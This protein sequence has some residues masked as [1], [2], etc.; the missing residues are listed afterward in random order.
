MPNLEDVIKGLECCDDMN[1]KTSCF[2]CPYLKTNEDEGMVGCT[3]ELARDALALLKEREPRVMTL[4]EVM[5]TPKGIAIWQEIKD[6]PD[7]K[8]EISPVAEPSEIT[9]DCNDD[10]FNL[11]PK[12]PIIGIRFASEGYMPKE[13]YGATWRCWTSRPTDEQRKVVKWDD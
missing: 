6:D 5:A 10:W 11:E 7:Y 12:E 4:E 1:T 13:T 2:I 9:I 8:F 3:A